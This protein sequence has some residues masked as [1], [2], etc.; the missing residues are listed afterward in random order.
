MNPSYR[1]KLLN[2]EQYS[3]NLRDKYEK[4]VNAMLEKKVTG[5]QK[6]LIIFFFCLGIVF[7]G[8]FGWAYFVSKGEMLPLARIIFIIGA[9]F[10]LLMTL[11]MGY[12]LKRGSWHEKIHSNA[13]M[14]L[15]WGF[16]IITS[17]FLLLLGS[18]IDPAKHTH[19]LVSLLV[20]W[21]MAIVMFI[22]HWIKQS[23]YKTYEKLLEIELRLAE[24]DE[25]IR[26]KE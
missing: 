17:T 18:Y 16:M 11:F 10:G 1:D 20:F 24:L 23:E 4:E 9:V 6:G 21:S 22:Q 12:I 2:A 8:V 7:I 26:K 13:M 5:F 19:V 15:I 3:P 25:K 14:G